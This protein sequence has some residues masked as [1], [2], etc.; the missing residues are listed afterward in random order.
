MKINELAINH[1]SPNHHYVRS[2]SHFYKAI[3]DGLK[4]H[5]LRDDDRNYQ[6]GDL[7]CLQEYDNIEGRYTGQ[8]L[9]TEV[10][11]ITGRATPCAYS[12]AVLQKGY[13]ILSIRVVDDPRTKVPSDEIPF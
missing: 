1:P 2:W 8:E 3:R 6:V 9:W 12:S 11:Y 4:T 7:I 5:D 10:T 13:V